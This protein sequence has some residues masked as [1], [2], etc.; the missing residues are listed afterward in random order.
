V[1]L[2][3]G[4]LHMLIGRGIILP[5]LIALIGTAPLFAQQRADTIGD[6]S[7]AVIAGRDAIVTYGLTPEQVKEL[8]KAAVAGA[9][10]PLTDRIVDLSNRL[11][12]TQGA[13]LTVLRILGRGDVPL[14]QLPQ[15]LAEVADQFQKAQA[16]LAALNPPEP[17]GAGSRRASPGRDQGW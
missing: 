5:L 1:M 2:Y 8:T 7:P 4:R 10:G 13:T 11:G 3:P 15:K 17:I 16:Q 6:Q 9:A 12:A 14:E